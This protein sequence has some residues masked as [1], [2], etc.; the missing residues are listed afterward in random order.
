M[1][2]SP[3]WLWPWA[4]PFLS[5]LLHFRLLQGS[6]FLFLQGLTL[7]RGFPFSRG[8]WDKPPPLHPNH[9]PGLPSLE[10]TPWRCQHKITNNQSIDKGNTVSFT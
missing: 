7:C 5:G 6:D 8:H 2:S 3:D 10:L 9:V 4:G 1:V